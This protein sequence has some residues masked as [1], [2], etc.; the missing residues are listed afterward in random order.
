MKDSYCD[1]DTDADVTVPVKAM[2]MFD[3][4]HGVLQVYNM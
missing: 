2:I 4:E 3:Y 1:T